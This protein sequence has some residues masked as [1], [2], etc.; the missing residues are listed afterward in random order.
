MASLTQV[1]EQSRRL[2]AWRCSAAL[3][4]AALQHAESLQAATLPRGLTQCAGERAVAS[5]GAGGVNAEVLT[6][7]GAKSC[8]FC[9]A[10]GS[11]QLQ[12]RNPLGDGTASM[13]TSR[14]LE[15]S[16]RSD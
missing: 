7:S 14:Q 4:C 15:A 8:H 12:M 5:G 16:Q 9:S 3:H 1:P 11:R 6:S 10:T 13:E 2:T